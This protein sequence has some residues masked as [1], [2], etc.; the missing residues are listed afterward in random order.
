MRA[1]RKPTAKSAQAR[2]P[3]L[4]PTRINTY[5][6]CAVKYRYIYQDKLGRFYSRARAGYSFGTTLH[7]VLQDFHTQ[8]ATQTPEELVSGLEQSWVATGYKTP[9]QEKEHQEAGKEIVQAYHAA[10]QARREAK[11]E[12]IATEK[13]ISCDMGRF[14]LSGRVDRIDRHAD[15]LL[16]VIDYKSGRWD[17]SVEEVANSLAMCCYQL[18]LKRNHPESRVCGTLYCLRSGIQATYALEGD[19]LEAFARDILEIGAEILDTDY[20]QLVP[21]PNK[22][23]PDCD[24]LP[25]CKRYW[26]QQDRGEMMV[27]PPFSEDGL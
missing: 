25:L 4:S 14:K 9:E 13:T 12:T 21:V 11:V 27:D 1:S 18:I 20:T 24:F 23:C 15:G 3:T 10:H 5:L 19:A 17:T 6:E 16:E 22:S 7:H 26:R 2:K 8:G